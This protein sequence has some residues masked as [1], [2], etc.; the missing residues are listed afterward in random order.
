MAEP[1]LVARARGH[2]PRPA[3]HAD[4]GSATHADLVAGAE[5]VAA[6][7]LAHEPSAPTSLDG[8][9]IAHLVAP[10]VPSTT[11]LWGTWLAGGVAVPLALSHP[12][13]E[14][15]RTLADSG[16]SALLVDRDRRDD[17]AALADDLGVRL[18]VVE[19]LP[20]AGEGWAG[21]DVPGSAPALIVYTSGSTGPPKGAVWTHDA[22]IQEVRTLES[23]W[24]YEPD[25][26][27]L[28]VLPLHHMHGLVNVVTTTLWAGGAVR[29]MPRFDPVAVWDAMADLTVVMAVPTIYHR[30]IA[31][32]E[33]APA[34]WR[35]RVCADAARLRLMVSG[36]A[37]LP[38]GVLERW[39]E[40]TGHVLLERY[41]MTEIGMALSNPHDGL[42][43]AGTVGRPLPGVEVRVVDDIGR[44][45]PDGEAGGLLVRGD[46][47]FRGYWGRP[48]ATAEAFRDGWFVTGDVVVRDHDGVFTIRGRESVDIIKTG[49][50][51]VSA[52]E[53]EEVLRDH[54]AV[55]DCAVVGLAD[56]EWGQVV[57]AA[58]VAPA[59]GE[60]P[61]GG[62]VVTWV[63]ERLAPYKVPRR[64]VVVD[65]LPRNALGKV[66]KP[67]VVAELF[68]RP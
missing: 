48:D 20:P 5:R 46:G 52:L 8:A 68:G 62:A 50:F 55:T 63:G 57:G 59:D 49:G 44:D 53:I 58:L 2:G 34:A 38:V 15:R 30:L 26:V 16:A 14:L 21:A 51:K 12:R 33:E 45:V 61:D 13:P 39:E 56:D 35:E 67:R 22:L 17:V 54:P 29:V 65:D 40:L 19:D 60:P 25:D 10:G 42:R 23:A 4:D 28:L 36:S 6:G 64:V 9:R 32:V 24:R 18:L 41:G 11:A 1:A 66:V 7:L 37:A 43:R 27:C 47:M 3:V 31:A